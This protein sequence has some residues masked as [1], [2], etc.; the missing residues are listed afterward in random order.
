[1]LVVELS[2]TRKK[3]R[4]W[5]KFMD[6]VKEVVQ[7]VG[8]IVEHAKESPFQVGE[9]DK[10]LFK[11]KSRKKTSTKSKTSEYSLEEMVQKYTSVAHFLL[12]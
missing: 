1:M 10:R 8:V 4:P 5:R 9:G 7:R 12:F 6:V 3:G 11:R 2:G